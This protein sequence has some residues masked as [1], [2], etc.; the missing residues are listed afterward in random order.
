MG[1]FSLDKK[2]ALCV[3]GDRAVKG[4]RAK[5]G[6]GIRIGCKV[7]GQQFGRETRQF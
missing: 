4:H 1:T 6:Q 7:V 2:T 3:K 5:V